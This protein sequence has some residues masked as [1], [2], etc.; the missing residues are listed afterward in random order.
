MPGLGRRTFAP[1]EVLT[2]TN[3]M[4]YLQDQAIMN[5][6]GTAAR[7]SAIGTAVSEGMV[8]YLADSN[9]I[10]SYSG[11]AWE[12]QTGGLVPIKPTSVVIATG[13]GTENTVGV[14]SFTGA[15]AVSLNGIFTS[16]YSKYRVMVDIT[17]NSILAESIRLRFRKAG[18]DSTAG[19]YSRQGFF[20]NGTTLTNYSEFNQTACHF[21][22][23]ATTA[24][25]VGFMDIFSPTARPGYISS[26][27]STNFSS[28]NYR[29]QMSGF[30]NVTDTFDGATLIIGSG[31]MTGNIQV[32]AYK[33]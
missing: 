27:Q 16:A 26:A 15:T 9:L 19:N 6:A 21:V 8:S 24:R 17:S 14:V 23:A 20:V 11:T 30:L 1:G 18:T 25:T 22:E 29:T 13:S 5:F 12:R 28:T 3:V 2:A 33:D 10:E 32:F 4:G 31:T 7:G